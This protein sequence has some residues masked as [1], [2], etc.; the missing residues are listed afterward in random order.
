MPTL[1]GGGISLFLVSQ[2]VRQTD[3]GNAGLYGKAPFKKI[4]EYVKGNH[5]KTQDFTSYM[6]KPG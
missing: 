4:L 2:G 3:C 6:K 5:Y 1:L